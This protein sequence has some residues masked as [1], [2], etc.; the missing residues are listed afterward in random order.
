MPTFVPLRYNALRLFRLQRGI[1]LLFPIKSTIHHSIWRR[2]FHLCLIPDTKDSCT[3]IHISKSRVFIIDPGIHKP[4][5]H[6]LSLQIQCCR[7]LQPYHPTDF[8]RSHI[9]RCQ[10]V[11]YR[12]IRII[13]QIQLRCPFPSVKA[14]IISII[15]LLDTLRGS[16]RITADIIQDQI[17]ILI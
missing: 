5:Q 10:A 15:H 2:T 9:H 16:H 17:I 11:R 3:S 6:T 8:Q 1:D 13:L 12:Q 14:N 7:I 4:D